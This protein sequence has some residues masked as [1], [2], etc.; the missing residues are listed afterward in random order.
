MNPYN[1]AL[2]NPLDPGA[3]NGYF[4]PDPPPD[5]INITFSFGSGVGAFISPTD[6]VDPW[7]GAVY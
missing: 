6:F 4:N 1:D 3:P 5:P 2:L 7:F